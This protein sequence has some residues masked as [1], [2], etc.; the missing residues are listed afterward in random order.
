MSRVEGPMGYTAGMPEAHDLSAEMMTCRE[1]AAAWRK[2]AKNCGPP[3]RDE[4]ISMAESLEVMAARYEWLAAH[5][6]AEPPDVLE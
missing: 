1:R 6:T 5:G 4:F 2:L 3:L